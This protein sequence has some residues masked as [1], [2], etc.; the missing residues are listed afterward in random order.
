MIGIQGIPFVISGIIKKELRMATAMEM[1]RAPWMWNPVNPWIV[2]AEKKI[3][4]ITLPLGFK[5]LSEP[6]ILNLEK[7]EKTA[8]KGTGR[9]NPHFMNELIEDV[10]EKLMESYVEVTPRYAAAA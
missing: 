3:N 2:E 8:R 10:S 9:H 6:T 1:R 4:K 7:I 5:I